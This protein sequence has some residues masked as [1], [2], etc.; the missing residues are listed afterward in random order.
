MKELF[1]P[2]WERLERE[3]L[4]RPE[5]KRAIG[6]GRKYHLSLPDMLLMT[7]LWL[8]R[9][10]NT[11]V[12]AFFLG[13]GRATVSRNTRRVLKTPELPGKASPGCLGRLIIKGENLEEALAEIQVTCPDLMALIMGRSSGFGVLRTMTFSA[14]IIRA[15]AKLI[16]ARRLW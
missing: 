3:R 16:L 12:L 13:V 6:G 9:Y 5:H 8:R 1:L 2:V 14:S 7:L 4:N 10:W 11:E 15:V